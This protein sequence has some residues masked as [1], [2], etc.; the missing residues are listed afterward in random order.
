[1]PKKPIT[2]KRRHRKQRGC[3]PEE[4]EFILPERGQDF[5]VVTEVHANCRFSVSCLHHILPT[6]AI[7]RGKMRKRL[8]VAVGDIVLVALRDFQP[9]KCDILLLYNAQE[10]DRILGV[11]A[12]S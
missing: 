10:R 6:L 11:A 7:L 5:A 4:R 12:P 2:G 1:M 8:W 9:E 3:T